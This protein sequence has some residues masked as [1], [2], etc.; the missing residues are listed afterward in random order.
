MKGISVTSCVTNT[1]VAPEACAAPATSRTSEVRV[2]R[3]RALN[4]SSR[5][6]ISGLRAKALARLTRWLSPP[7]SA[8]AGLRARCEMP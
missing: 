1:V 3:S 4:G 8:R 6:S 2:G 7:E 5:K